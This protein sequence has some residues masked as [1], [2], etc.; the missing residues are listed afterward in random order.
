MVQKLSEGRPAPVTAEDWVNLSN[1]GVGTLMAV[2]DTALD[3][4]GAYAAAQLDSARENAAIAIVLMLASIALASFAAIYLMWGVIRPLRALTRSM[5]GIAGG[6]LRT[7]IPFGDR[8]D[9]IGRFA[10]AL[11]LFRDSSL[12]R[13]HLEKELLDSRVAQESAETLQPGQVGVPG[14]YEPRTAH[15]R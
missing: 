1:A 12:A 5:E 13:V 15:P 4:T 8:Q 11:T 10:G 7:E 14:Q 2:P 6:R 3:L 9:E